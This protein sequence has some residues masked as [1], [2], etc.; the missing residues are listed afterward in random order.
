MA[1][2]R[3]VVFRVTP[4]ELAAVADRVTAEEAATAAAS[5]A[6]AA[7][8]A[9]ISAE[10]VATADATAARAVLSS[11]IAAADT[12]LAT[13]ASATDLGALDAR[14]VGAEAALLGKADQTA[15]DASLAA[16]AAAYDGPKEAAHQALLVLVGADGALAVNQQPG[17][18]NTFVYDGTVQTLS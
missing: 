6:A 11:Q 3:S 9:R 2:Y 18:A 16:V 12:A 17:S 1:Q 8:A 15:V 10:E 7:L 13:K 14:V 5:A 4:A